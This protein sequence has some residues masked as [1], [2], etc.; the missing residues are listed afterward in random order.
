MKNYVQR[1]D[2]LEL[3]APAGGVVSG[4]GYKIGR[5]F[6]VATVTAA[7]GEKFSGVI[8]GVVDIAKVAA[9]PWSEGL[10]IYWNSGSSLAT[11]ISTTA[12]LIGTAVRTEANPTSTGRV[13]LNYG[14][15]LNQ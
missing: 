9:E 1:G 13:K 5:F 12:L 6:A 7:V 8:E 14:S 2:V 15:W 4:N 10:L 11:S 3:T